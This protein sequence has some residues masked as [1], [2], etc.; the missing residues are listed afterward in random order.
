P[1]FA[2]LLRSFGV[3]TETLTF[4]YYTTFFQRAYY[5]EALG[6]SILSA[7]ITTIIVLF[8]SINVA[9]YATRMKA[10]FAKSYRVIALLLLVAPPFKFSLALIII[11]GRNGVVAVYIT[12]VFG[13]EFSI[14]DFWSVV[15][16][17]IICYF[18]IGYILVESTL[19]S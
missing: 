4:D 2:V 6:N 10:F 13:I 14:Y 3:G 5:W 1:V 17:Q 11:L 12:D 8:L 19:Q 15:L 7:V 18:P 16:A 9:L